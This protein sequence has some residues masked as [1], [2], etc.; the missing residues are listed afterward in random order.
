MRAVLAG[1]SPRDAIEEGESLEK[2]VDPYGLFS[3]SDS[4]ST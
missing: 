3:E 2:H 1:I 4:K